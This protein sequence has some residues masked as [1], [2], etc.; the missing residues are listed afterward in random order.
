MPIFSTW[1]T[2]GRLSRLL[3]FSDVT[4]AAVDSVG[5]LLII[6]E[7]SW[8]VATVSSLGLVGVLAGGAWDGGLVNSLCSKSTGLGSGLCFVFFR[9]VFLVNFFVDEEGAAVGP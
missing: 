5:S 3:F 9:G 2:G 4:E 8:D 7:A 1:L 6:L